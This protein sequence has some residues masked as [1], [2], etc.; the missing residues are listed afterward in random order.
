MAE[1]LYK[2]DKLNPIEKLY[3][4]VYKIQEKK[5]EDGL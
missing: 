1:N 3:M 2:L 5:R 4:F